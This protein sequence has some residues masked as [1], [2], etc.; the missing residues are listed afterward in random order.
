MELLPESRHGKTEDSVEKSYKNVKFNFIQ[1]TARY[2]LIYTSFRL[3]LI[4]L[5]G[6]VSH[7]NPS[8]PLLLVTSMF[9]L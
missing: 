1:R 2:L 5:R 4:P 8:S 6:G 7:S 9:F 3:E